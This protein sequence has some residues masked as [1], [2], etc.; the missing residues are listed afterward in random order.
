MLQQLS[1]DVMFV[2]SERVVSRGEFI[3]IRLDSRPSYLA[4]L[5]S[6]D[7]PFDFLFMHKSTQEIGLLL[8]VAKGLYYLAPPT[9]ISPSY[10]QDNQVS[11]ILALNGWQ[12][13]CEQLELIG[14]DGVV[15]TLIGSDDEPQ[16]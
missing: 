15:F 6:K 4:L 11:R 1:F 8:P 10:K 3:A 5:R 16:W 12:A 13:V 2:G 9:L 7:A 14:Y